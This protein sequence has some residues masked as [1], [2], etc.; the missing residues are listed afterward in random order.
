[1]LGRGIFCRRR[2]GKLLAVLLCIVM[3][4]VLA[5]AVVF[6]S[7]D[8]KKGLP[9]TVE[10]YY[11]GEPDTARTETLYA[12]EP[13]FIVNEE[14]IPYKGGPGCQPDP[15][16]PYEPKLPAVITAEDN[17]IKVFYITLPDYGQY[18]PFTVEYYYDGVLDGSKTEIINSVAPDFMVYE[19]L[20]PN[21]AGPGYQPDPETPYEPE[22]PALVILGDTVI[23][24]FYTAL[25]DYGQ[26]EPYTVEYYYD[27]E[28]DISKTESF[29]AAAPDFMVYEEDIP[30][31]AAPAYQ[32]DFGKPYEPVLPTVIT[33]E[34]NVIRVYYLGIPDYA[35]PIPFTVNYYYDGVLDESKTE[36]LN[37]VP[38]DY[39]VDESCFPDK[40]GPGYIPDPGKPYEPELPVHPWDG[41]DVIS[42]FYVT[43]LS[44]FGQ[45]TSYVVEYYYDG[46]LDESKTEVLNAAA[47]DYYIYEEMIPDKAEPGYILDPKE[48]YDPK[49]PTTAYGGDRLVKVHYVSEAA[50]GAQKPDP[51]VNNKSAKSYSSSEGAAS[52]GQETLPP[53]SVRLL[54]RAP[55]S[56]PSIA[57]PAVQ[58]QEDLTVVPPI[59][60]PVLVEGTPQFPLAAG[61]GEDKPASQGPGKGFIILVL[62]V[63]GIAFLVER[64][65]YAH[66]QKSYLR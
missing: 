28:L 22:L 15:G 47:P 5:S 46:E 39:I 34:N 66:E 31:K 9:Y 55:D 59:D 44:D 37:A 65:T 2:N 6:A 36:V 27:G 53:V 13:D 35:P 16:M 19:E 43:R 20:I 40:A 56:P 21:K 1:M 10:Y 52:Q 51:A 38:P 32:P 12:A 58:Q 62:A 18:V 63:A 7:A 60:R 42:V 50:S 4:G 45:Y 29:D 33:P 24:V 8:E 57:E 41:N 25:P 14:D 23:K 30:D 49:L 48:P 17:V 64:I 11:D 26:Y 61:S 54:E 3:V